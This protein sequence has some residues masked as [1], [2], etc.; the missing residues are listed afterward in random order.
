MIA[1]GADAVVSRR[2]MVLGRFRGRITPTSV[3]YTA[4]IVAAVAYLVV[5]SRGWFFFD[6]YAFLVPQ[7]GG[8][9]F[10]PHVGHW[11][12]VPVELFIAIRDLFGLN[13]YIPFVIPVIIAALAFAHVV[14]RFMLRVGVLAPI[15]TAI[16]L[17]LIFFGAGA[18]N[19]LWAFQ[20][21][22]VGAMTLVMIVIMIL[23]K[24]NLTRLDTALIIILSILSL[25]SSGTS[26]P[27]LVVAAL[28]GWLRHGFWR[29]VA[30]LA[31]PGVVYLAWFV[32]IGRFGA[33]SGR[34]TGL[35]QIVFNVPLFAVSML[36]DG[37]GH[38][39]PI[40]VL[41]PIVFAGVAIWGVLSYRDAP[42]LRRPAYILF[43]AAPVFA[44]F[45]AYS[46][47]NLGIETATSSRYL[48]FA[49]PMMLPLM[50]LGATS[51]VTR[52]GLSVPAVLVLIGALVVY[53][54]GGLV[55][56]VLERQNR[57]ETARERLSAAVVL[58]R[59]YP[60][61]ADNGGIRPAI[62]WAPDVNMQALDWWVKD[63]WFRA[64][65]YGAAAELTERG[66][67]GLAAGPGA[68]PS[69]LSGCTTVAPG[70]TPAT[71][72]G[73]DLEIHVVSTVTATVAL[74]RSGVTG[75][76]ASLKLNAGWNDVALTG[77]A[78]SNARLVVYAAPPAT[79]TVCPKP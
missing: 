59:Q 43:L 10:L 13:S 57:A 58:E 45:T 3:H 78:V 23:M 16:S 33:T 34:A 7:P 41:G 21:G 74:G 4:L 5:A 55:G 35:G 19:I 75:D 61:V 44:L 27:L 11:S 66:L 54:L 47:V 46:R 18:E 77:P 9:V 69:S 60:R 2:G 32:A 52:F 67:F 31:L 71:V 68:Q 15:A 28:I 30:V 72:T 49:I 64:G 50:A 63:G 17:L 12:T 70:G 62:Q 29:T 20:I 51:L 1:T 26:L 40:E 56:S 73:T 48:Y 24:E 42:S 6:D 14:W 38:V 39:F 76:A 53:N 79:L 36:T 25:A 65:R 8:N 37:L 22:F